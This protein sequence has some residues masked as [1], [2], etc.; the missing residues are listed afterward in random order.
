MKISDLTDRL[1]QFGLTHHEA[2]I[3]FHLEKLGAAT[4]AAVATTAGVRREKS[5]ELLR[6]LMDCGL[7]HATLERP[8]RFVAAPLPEAMERLMAVQQNKV[9]ALENTRQ[10]LLR[11]WPQAFHDGPVSADRFTLHQDATQVVA[12][13]NRMVASATREILVAVPKRRWTQ[14]RRWNVAGAVM[15][16]AAKGIEV[17]LLFPWQGDEAAWEDG[18]PEHVKIREGAQSPYHQIIIVDGREAGIFV[19]LGNQGG[20]GASDETLLWINAPDFVMSQTATFDLMWDSASDAS[21]APGTHGGLPVARF[22]TLRGR[23]ARYEQM[24]KMV[25]RARSSIS[26]VTTPSEPGRAERA[27]LADELAAA[28][29]RGVSVT[30][31]GGDAIGPF[32]NREFGEVVPGAAPIGALLVDGQEALIVS[33]MDNEPEALATDNEWSTWC[34]DPAVVHVFEAALRGF[35]VRAR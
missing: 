28:R 8:Q 25:A 21:A 33:G 9:H 20:L 27:G 30:I 17:R 14:L 18:T 26:Y 5:Y 15:D 35:I 32:A 29:K 31:M 3:Y 2:V 13:L 34:G 4:A 10:E 11:S 19:S 24:R 1:T 12:R 7:A 16:R 6:R 23:W 22:A